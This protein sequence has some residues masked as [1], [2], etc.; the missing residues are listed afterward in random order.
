MEIKTDIIIYFIKIFV[1][2]IYVYY[3]YYKI[4]NLRK[5][6]FIEKIIIY[7]S[8]YFITAIG[9]YIKFYMNAFFSMIIINLLNG[10]L[11][12]ILKKNKFGYSLIMS[13]ISYTICSLFLV[14]SAVIMFLPYK[15]IGIQNNYINLVFILVL[16]FVLLYAFLKIKK[17]KNGFDFLYKKVSNDLSDIVVVNLSI[18]LIIIAC[19]VGN[20][21]EGL[22]G[23]RRNLW[24]TYIILAIILFIMIQKTFTI[25]YKQKLM[26]DALGEYKKEIKEKDE[27]IKKLKDEKFN[28]SKITHE[29][30]NRQ[31]A[32]ELL[33]KENM[34]DKNDISEENASENVL[35]IIKSLTEEYSEE[36]TNIKKLS[37]LEKTEIPE[38][39]AMFKYMQS[40]CIKS[41]IEF[42]LKVIGNIYP[43]INNIIPKNKLE[44][45][46][47][48][49]L[50]DAIRAVNFADNQKKEIFAIL[51]IKDNKYELS[52]FD[53]GVEFKVETLLKLGLEP[54]TI[55]ANKGGTGIGF[56]TTFETLKETKASLIIKELLPEKENFY[57][58]SITIRFDGKNQYKICSYRVDEIKK[59][60]NSNNR[61][62]IENL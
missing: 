2:N 17:F 55:Y 22:E 18:I 32:M 36:L 21:N 29:F 38:I 57:T 19:V 60:N 49:H 42:K 20:I 9:T 34:N 61:I 1:V 6:N 48:D 43:L 50:R 3:F 30:Y 47:G 26:E 54:V 37:E 8:N 24:I 52:I 13:I 41:N 23:I 53:T 58:K 31:K 7:I 59:Y 39:D 10:I 56:L 12:G 15:I 33:I 27:E 35:N 25:Y 4:I 16:Q 11:L 46:I 44:T 5:Y 62:V 51:G 28:I 45:L 40:E 14:V